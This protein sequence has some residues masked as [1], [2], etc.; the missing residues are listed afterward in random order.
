MGTVNRVNRYFY[1]LQFPDCP[2]ASYV[3]IKDASIVAPEGRAIERVA[4]PDSLLER[5]TPVAGPRDAMEQAEI[6]ALAEQLYGNRWQGVVH[7]A[8][9]VRHRSTLNKYFYQVQFPG[10]PQMSCVAIKE[11]LPVEE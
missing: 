2:H 11:D 5:L 6:D 1:Q 7:T 8:G 3:A 4:R 10:C 9:L